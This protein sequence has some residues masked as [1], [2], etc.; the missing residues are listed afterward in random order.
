MVKRIIEN[1]KYLGTI[2]FLTIDEIFLS[3]KMETGTKKPPLRLILIC[4][5][6]KEIR[7]I[8]HMRQCGRKAF[9]KN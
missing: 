4:D 8:E 3:R 5:D 6:L 7:R 2:I 1:E 9:Q